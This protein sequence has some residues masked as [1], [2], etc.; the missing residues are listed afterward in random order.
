MALLRLICFPNTI[1][2]ILMYAFRLKGHTGYVNSINPARRGNPLIVSGSGKCK[3]SLEIVHILLIQKYQ[4]FCRRLLHQDLGSE[5]SGRYQYVK[6]HL[7][8]DGC[9]IQ[10][11]CGSSGNFKKLLLSSPWNLRFQYLQSPKSGR[12]NYKLP[13]DTFFPLLLLYSWV[14]SRTL[15]TDQCWHR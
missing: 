5:A 3:S 14:T 15:I 8:S 1:L 2:Q 7:P 9:L 4:T 12:K 10:R 6:Q 11:C 13:R